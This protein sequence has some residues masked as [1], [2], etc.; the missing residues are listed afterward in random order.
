MPRPCQPAPGFEEAVTR[1][2]EA[3][4]R[5]PARP[6]SVPGFRGAGV[7]VPLLARPA[8]PTIL[9]TVRAETLPHHRGEISFPGGGCAPGEDAAAAAL[10]ELEEEVGLPRAGLE[11]LGALDD[12]PSISRYVV[13]PFAAAVRDPPA[14]F[15]HAAAEVAE[16]FEVPL[17][18]LLDPAIRRASLWDPARLPPEAAE[19]LRGL[20][21][22]PEEVDPGT[23]HWRVWSFH[24][25][26]S[27]NVW[28][29]T[30]RILADLLDRAFGRGT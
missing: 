24:P 8:G 22:A 9:F 15:V 27:R 18:T 1:I 5:R 25:E 23:G 13:T 6:L 2:R 3:L 12:L 7:V 17:A 19:L 26:P 20:E 30:A 4:A 21:V 29:L 16:G 11:L 28:G 10:R 14:R